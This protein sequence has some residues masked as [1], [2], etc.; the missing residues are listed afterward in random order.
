MAVRA[1]VI[2]YVSSSSRRMAMAE[3]GR[4][5]VTVRVM[6]MLRVMARGLGFDAAGFLS[7]LSCILHYAACR[8]AQA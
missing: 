2:E 4:G 3:V 5:V 6:I 1:T 8:M 7:L